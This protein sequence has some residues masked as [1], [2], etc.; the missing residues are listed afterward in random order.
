MDKPLEQNN[1][2][3]SAS[4][5]DNQVVCEPSA[6]NIPVIRSSEVDTT[7][8]RRY[9]FKYLISPAKAT[10]MDNY[11]AEYLPVDRFS[12]KYP[13]GFYDIVSLYLDSPDLRLCRESMTGVLN[14]YKL[15]IRTYSD[16]PT[17]PR[18]FEIK[19]RANTVIIKSRA[20]VRTEDVEHILAGRY[21]HP[22]SC[23]PE[24]IDRLKQFMLYMQS[25]NAGP[26]I[27]I[28]YKRKAYEG[29]AENRVRI[30]FD[31]ELCFKTNNE[32]YVLL[33]G[34]DWQRNNIC[35]DWVILEIKYTG[36]FPAW[37]NRMIEYFN[38][39]QRSVSKYSA[40][41]KNAS[42]LKFCAPKLPIT[43]E[44]LED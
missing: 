26:V 2:A 28:R 22:A 40:S 21:K 25:I 18:F 12:K 35:L 3:S 41:L 31:K 32:P 1:T 19:R 16:D 23:N 44:G 15:R 20:K 6:I 24:E 36:R 34:N 9:E 29:I 27:L 10:A 14:R 38:I 4:S 43:A 5:S 7:L 11:V 42:I 37:L 33:S 8:K 30:T 17:T 13:D 39:Q